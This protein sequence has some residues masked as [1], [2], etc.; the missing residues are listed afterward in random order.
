MQAGLSA[1]QGLTG[2]TLLNLGGIFGTALLG[3]LASRYALR[4]VL[5]AY[6][7]ATAVLLALFI[8]ATSS[9]AVAFIIGAI[10]GIFVNGCVAGLYAVT[11]VAYDT[12]IRATGVGTAIGIGRIGAILSPIAAGTLLDLGWSAQLLYIA[13]GIVFILAAALLWLVRIEPVA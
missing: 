6:L 13:V 11:A 5:I 4:S 3:L 12:G 1:S 2:G 8:T 9:L 7:I 10:I